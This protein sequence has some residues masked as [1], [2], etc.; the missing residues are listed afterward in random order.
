MF[1]CPVATC[2]YSTRGLPRSLLSP[3]AVWKGSITL[4]PWFSP[5]GFPLLTTPLQAST[6]YNLAKAAA[7]SHLHLVSVDSE[8]NQD[9]TF[10]EAGNINEWSGWCS[11]QWG[12]MGHVVMVGGRKYPRQK[13]S[14]VVA[15]DYPCPW[16][17]GLKDLRH[18][19]TFT[20]WQLKQSKKSQLT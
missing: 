1:T 4:A 20:C 10:L 11:S 12:A 9:P 8:H 6:W 5:A 14:H 16:E 15:S 18:H 2:P 13:S 19:P 3:W 7:H 17:H